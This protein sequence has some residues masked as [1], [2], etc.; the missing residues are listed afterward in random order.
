RLV[1][2]PRAFPNAR[3]E[4]A[5]TDLLVRPDLIARRYLGAS[6]EAITVINLTGDHASAILG[7]PGGGPLVN[8]TTYCDVFDD[9]TYRVAGGLIAVSVPPA[10]SNQTCA[11]D[12]P[13][14][15][16]A[17]CGLRVL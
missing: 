16:R 3:V 7:K 9:Q 5:Q 10:P 14:G 1:R 15:S 6:Q 4:G 2:I 12:V 11:Y 13:A 17:V 8:D